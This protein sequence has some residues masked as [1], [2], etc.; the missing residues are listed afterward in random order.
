MAKKKPN[1][2]VVGGVV[3]GAGVLIYLLTRSKGPAQTPAEKVSFRKLTERG[4]YDVDEEIEIRRLPYDGTSEAA[5]Y[6][7][8][9]TI[10]GAPKATLRTAVLEENGE[11]FVLLS[12][13]FR[14]PFTTNAITVS[15]QFNDGTV[16][17]ILYGDVSVVQP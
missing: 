15:E 16:E 14:E 6:L 11:Q 17:D 7:D 1:P 8:A 9:F 5:D 13:V 12:V 4:E 3:V 2:V 10:D